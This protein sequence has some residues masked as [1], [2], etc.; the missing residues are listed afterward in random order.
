MDAGT[1]LKCPGK[2]L[3]FPEHSQAHFIQ[4]VKIDRTSILL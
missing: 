3:F 4:S 2:F 1:K